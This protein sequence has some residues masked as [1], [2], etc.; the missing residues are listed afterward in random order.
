MVLVGTMQ[1]P[2]KGI[3]HELCQQLKHRE[4]LN[5][6]HKINSASACTPA[7]LTKNQRLNK[8]RRN[9]IVGTQVY[10]VVDELRINHVVDK[11]QLAEKLVD[12]R[13]SIHIIEKYIR[14]KEHSNFIDLRGQQ[15]KLVK[16]IIEL[17][18]SRSKYM[19]RP[20]YYEASILSLL[21]REQLFMDQLMQI[22]IKLDQFCMQFGV[23][24]QPF[25][26]AGN[27]V[28][29]VWGHAAKSLLAKVGKI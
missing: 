20:Q 13:Q 10:E 16:Q 26:E 17:A 29:K 4:Q 15:F 21:N 2:H 5:T 3:L 19:E 9:F 18:L 24:G 25:A 11:Q 8:E 12:V 7:R 22:D 28:P 23:S 14:L 27:L 6:Q 1:K